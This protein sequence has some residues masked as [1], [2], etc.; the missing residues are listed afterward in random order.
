MG[1]NDR[2]LVAELYEIPF[3]FQMD[4]Q[5]AYG[6]PSGDIIFEKRSVGLAE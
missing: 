3:D 1:G 6:S 4:D 5:Q 2:V